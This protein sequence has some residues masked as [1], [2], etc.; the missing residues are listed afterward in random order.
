MA[1]CIVAGAPEVTCVEGGPA[2]A[3]ARNAGSW[4]GDEEGTKE[5]IQA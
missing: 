1:L 2:W 4:E 5:R 3:E